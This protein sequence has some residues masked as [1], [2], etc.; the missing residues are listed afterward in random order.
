V[1]NNA[2]RSTLVDL[3]RRSTVFVP[4]IFPVT[5]NGLDNLRDRAIHAPSDNSDV[6]LPYHEG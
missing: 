2:G 5:Q 6:A 1:V 4:L 3:I